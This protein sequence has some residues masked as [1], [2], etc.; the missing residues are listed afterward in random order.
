[1]EPGSFLIKEDQTCQEEAKQ[2]TRQNKFAKPIISKKGMRAGVC[3]K[4]RQSGE[5]GQPL[6]KCMEEDLK[7]DPEVNKSSIFHPRKKEEKLEAKNRRN[8]QHLCVLLL[9]KSSPYTKE[10]QKII[11]HNLRSEEARIHAK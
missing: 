1:M 9:L 10:T 5:R 8:V 4:R 7:E 3:L 6:I 11:Q 2:N